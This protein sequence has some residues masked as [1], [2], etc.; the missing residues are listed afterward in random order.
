MKEHNN[1]ILSVPIHL[2]LLLI[3][4]TTGFL[5]YGCTVKQTDEEA[6]VVKTVSVDEGDYEPALPLGITSVDL[7]SDGTV[8]INNYGALAEKLGTTHV[9]FDN[10]KDI[11]CCNYGNGGYRV[12]LV[13][14]SDNTISA[15]S[16]QSLIEHRRYRV[17]NNLGDFKDVDTIEQFQDE[18]ASGILVKLQDGSTEFLDDFLT[19]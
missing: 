1:K 5:A 10:S 4:L 19:F 18:Y 3:I 8:V 17:K 2:F 15:I 11:F 6:S 12:I 14:K 13:I 9:A 7:M 16:G